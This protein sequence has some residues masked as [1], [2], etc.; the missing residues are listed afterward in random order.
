MV[1]MKTL[2]YKT[3]QYPPTAVSNVPLAEFDFYINNL[4]AALR[5]HLNWYQNYPAV[6]KYPAN[7]KMYKQFQVIIRR[8]TGYLSGEEKP[9]LWEVK[10]HDLL[11]WRIGELVF[12]G[13][14][15]SVHCL[16]CG[17][18]FVFDQCKIENWSIGEGLIVSG[19][20]NLVCPHGHLLCHVEEWNS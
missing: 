6:M 4:V 8:L 20:R 11:W 5:E 10:K 19:G 3:F 13:Q 15:S 18:R 2:R 14:F 9:V 16:S 1:V 12:T 17:D 7:R